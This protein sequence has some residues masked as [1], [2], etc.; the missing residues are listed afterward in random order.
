MEHLGNLIYSFRKERKLS[1]DDFAE[2]SGLSKSYISRLEKNVHPITEQAI[3]PSLETFAAVARA[4]GHSI[5]DLLINYG[6]DTFRAIGELI[7]GSQETVNRILLRDDEFRL[8]S[9]TRRFKAGAE[10]LSHS[11]LIAMTE[12]IPASELTREQ[13]LELLT[14][15]S[16]AEASADQDYESMSDSDLRDAYERLRKKLTV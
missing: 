4:T 12:P 6:D 7:N 8:Y 3:N 9:K 2:L 15:S 10:L 14:E 13:M 11:I 16:K 1:M 5:A